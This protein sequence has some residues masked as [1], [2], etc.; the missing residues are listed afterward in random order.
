MGLFVNQ[1]APKNNYTATAAPTA[2]D[3]ATAGYSQGS[4]WLNTTS[5]IQ[6]YCADATA[7]AAV[8]IPAT[9]NIGTAVASRFFTPG[10]WTMSNGTAFA[11]AL[12][13]VVALMPISVP[14][15]AAVVTLNVR[16]ATGA[17]SSAIKMALWRNNYATGR[18]TGVPFVGS[19]TGQATTG[20]NS[21]QSVAAVFT[22]QPNVMYWFGC[23]VTTAAPTFYGVQGSA[24]TA[25]SWGSQIIGEGTVAASPVI[26]LSAPYAYA[27]D[28]MALDLS[29]ATFTTLIGAQAIPIPRLGT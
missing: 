4:E 21:T 24:T 28:I 13:T 2:T 11:P 8:W 1:I 7:S 16:T 17:G 23:A 26:G 19:N 27:N 3:D 25:T 29:A 18:P 22:A 10:L 14:F 20:N 6:W 5:N 15:R 12:D 9:S